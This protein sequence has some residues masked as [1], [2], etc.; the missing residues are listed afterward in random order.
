MCDCMKILNRKFD[1]VIISFRNLLYTLLN[2]RDGIGM[3]N[4][5][6]FCLL[7]IKFC[8]FQT[9]QKSQNLLELQLQN[10]Y[11]IL[12]VQMYFPKVLFF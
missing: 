4:T 12:K 8:M 6:Y 7:R 2:I 1:N 3:I 5:F 9:E 10:L 11:G